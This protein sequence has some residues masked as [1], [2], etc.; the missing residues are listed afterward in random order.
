MLLRTGAQIMQHL[1]LLALA[2]AGNLLVITAEVGECPMRG[3][4]TEQGTGNHAI[5][6]GLQFAR[7]Q[8]VQI[9]AQTRAQQARRGHYR[10]GQRNDTLDRQA[11]AGEQQADGDHVLIANAPDTL[12]G[13]DRIQEMDVRAGQT[14]GVAADHS[15]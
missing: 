5:A 13:A 3:T 14:C 15:R 12:A 6:A 11:P 7:S 10:T 8:L 9:G 2:Q 4:S 1:A